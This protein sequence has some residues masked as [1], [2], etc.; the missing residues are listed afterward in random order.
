MN[1]SFLLNIKALILMGGRGARFKSSLP[2]QFHLIGGK[3]IYLHTLEQFV[4]SGLFQEIILV[5]TK[6]WIEEVKQ[7]VE[8]YPVRVI[9]GGETR[10]DSSYLGLLACGKDTDLVVIHDA[11]RPFVSQRILLE[12]VEACKKY[13]A[14]DTCIPATDTLVKTRDGK[15][16]DEIP[17]RAHFMRG[18][19]PQSFSYELI[20]EAHE[21]AKNKLLIATDDCSLVLALGRS[22][23]IVA[24][25]EANIK[26]TTDFDLH[27]ADQLLTN[28]DLAAGEV[29][30]SDAP[31]VDIFH[32]S[33][34]TADGC[35][36]AYHSSS[37]PKT[38]DI[39]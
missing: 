2:K 28:L 14:V 38:N 9:A 25:E 15:K 35:V 33:N 20:L 18:Q 16:I 17:H 30:V 32:E 19:T 26:I 34:Q 13:N 29:V 8:G 3:K 11:V 23:H 39:S 36:D 24:G 5:C 4:K 6:E 27:L 1:R 7:E 10:Q 37:E 21:H 12:N 22:V 31:L